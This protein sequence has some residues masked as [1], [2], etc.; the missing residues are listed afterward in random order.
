MH[1]AFFLGKIKIGQ[2]AYKKVRKS[3]ITVAQ[4]HISFFAAQIKNANKIFLLRF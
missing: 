3:K 1:A 2:N 4:L